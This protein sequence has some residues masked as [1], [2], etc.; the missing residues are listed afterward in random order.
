MK[1]AII[2]CSGGLDSIT[3]AYY[4]KKKLDYEDISV[5]FFNYGQKSLDKER[6]FS[7]K[8]AVD[9]GGDFIEVDFKWLG[10][11]SNSLINKAGKINKLSVDD[12]KDTKEEAKSWYVPNRNSIFLNYAI[13]LA[14]SL[15]GADIFVGFK[16]EGEENY[17][18]TTPGFM[19]KMNELVKVACSNEINIIA[20][21]IKKDK[22]DII[23]M[24]KTL[25][26]DFK[27]TFSC[28]IEKEKHCGYCLACKLRQQGFKWANI[29][30][31]TEYES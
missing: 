22:E 10:E 28:Y 19:K 2:L 6:E 24:G 5:M 16:N 13:A 12:L 15:E 17:P 29:E 3:T 1:K 26:V 30:D 25:G 7:R 20:P 18:D 9:L 4:V 23:H 31:P 14:E 8:C 21:F 11:L 27:K